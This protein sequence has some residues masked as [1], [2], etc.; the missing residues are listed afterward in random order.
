MNK[1]VNWRERD[2]I[3]PDSCGAPTIMEFLLT[4]GLPSGPIHWTMTFP[5]TFSALVIRH[6]KEK[7]SP[8][9]KFPLEF[10]ATVRTIM[11]TWVVT[12]F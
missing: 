3:D 8:A 6:L 1:E 9:A 7:A 10:T 2:M 11:W 12:Y 4:N 5:V